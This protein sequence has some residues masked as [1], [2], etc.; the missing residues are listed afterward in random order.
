MN[1]PK[2]ETFHDVIPHIKDYPEF[3]IINKGDYTVINYM[4]TKDSTFDIDP[5]DPIPGMIRRECRGIKFYP[6]GDIAS[7]PFHKFFNIGE[8]EE[9]QPSKIDLTKSHIIQQKLDGTMIT[10]VGFNDDTIRWMTKMGITDFTFDV[11][12]Y[13][14]DKSNYYEFAKHCIENNYTPIFEWCSPKNQV[15]IYYSKPQLTLLAVRD[16]FTGDY[17]EYGLALDI[18]KFNIPFVGL[19]Y[20]EFN[21]IDNLIEYVKPLENQE[22][23]IIRFDDGSRYKIKADLYL[24]MHRMVDRVK[25]NRHIAELIFD[26]KLD[27]VIGLLTDIDK[28]RVLDYKAVLL[29]AIDNK[30]NFIKDH[31]NLASKQFSSKADIAKNYIPHYMKNNLD[32][33]I[34]FAAIDDKDIRQSIISIIR[35]NV[36]SNT[37][38]S[39]LEQNW[40]QIKG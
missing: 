4:V 37:K 36:I 32:K 39:E 14:L 22:G 26:E 9:T 21:S 27:D 13:L 33:T 31:Y 16:N 25:H 11:E 5:D 17:I 2:I 40:L 24:K 18:V 38:Y 1:F 34:L 6:N 10:P 12:N 23:F 3:N 15:V 35:K 7:R 8:R 20:Q 30:Y 28:T 29:N 19:L